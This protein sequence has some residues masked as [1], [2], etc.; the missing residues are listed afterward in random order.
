MKEPYVLRQT[1]KLDLENYVNSPN[2][3]SQ[4]DLIEGEFTTHRRLQLE[5]E[6]LAHQSIELKMKEQLNGQVKKAA[7]IDLPIP[8]DDENSN[9]IEILQTVKTDEMVDTKANPASEYVD[10]DALRTK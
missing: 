7:D 8:Y 5:E 1:D 6:S 9:L 3:H 2:D 10:L 4:Q